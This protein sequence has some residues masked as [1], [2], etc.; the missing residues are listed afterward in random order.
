MSRV[1]RASVF[2]ALGDPVRLELL[3]RMGK[4]GSI[5]TLA[6]GLP[7]TRQAV[8]RHLRVLERAELIEARRNGREMLFTARPARMAEA[9]SWLDDVARQWDGTLER[10]KA[11]VEK[12]KR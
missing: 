1:D 8:T 5:T 11:H 9:K 2:A 6:A 12:K 7:I 10:L 3:A 4:G